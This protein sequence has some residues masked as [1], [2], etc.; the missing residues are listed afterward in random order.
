M[1]DVKNADMSNQQNQD[2]KNGA[3]QSNQPIPSPTPDK[4]V[5]QGQNGQSGTDVNK[6]PQAQPGEKT[7]SALLLK[8]LQEERAARRDLEQQVAN[9][10]GQ[11]T[12]PQQQGQAPVNQ[13]QQ[14]IDEMWQT[15]DYR[16]AMQAEMALSFQWFDQVNAKLDT[17]R[18]TVRAKYP[19]FSRYEGKAMGYVR[20][21][22][23]EQRAKDG[24]VELAYL[25]QKGQDSNNIYQQAQQEIIEKLRRGESIQGLSAGTG[26]P[27]QP[28][29]KQPTEDMIRAA[30]AMNVPIADYMASMK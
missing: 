23:L 13:F 2:V 6:E 28:Q 22:P 24:V 29:G 10:M 19:D 8:S 11:Q 9:L 3:D 12:Q 25:V 4:D 18:E 20:T 27:P 16:R 14:Q 15:G 30:E 17:Q 7:D 5:K 26:Q 21:L 1:A